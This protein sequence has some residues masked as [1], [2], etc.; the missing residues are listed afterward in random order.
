MTTRS[1]CL[2]T[3]MVLLCGCGGGAG[4]SSGNGGSSGN[5]PD[6]LSTADQTT[7]TAIMGD[8]NALRAQCGGVALADVSALNPLIISATKH[9]GYQALYDA[10]DNGNQPLLTHAEPDDI[11]ALYVN[12]AFF[13]RIE[14]AN[15][16]NDI[17]NWASYYEDIASQAGQPAITSLWNTVF[18]RLAMMRQGVT[19]AGYGDMAMAR[20]DYP[21]AHVATTDLWG[22]TPAGNGYAT[23][24]FTGY[25]TPSVTF[26]YWP[27]SG[28]TGVPSS[29]DTTTESPNP[30][31]GGP[32]VVGPP[33]HVICPTTENF[34]TLTVNLT[35]ASNHHLSVYVIVG[36]TALPTTITGDASASDA[37]VNP[38][39]LYPGE[40]FI[41][42]LA[43][44]AA[45]ST[46]SYWFT[47]SD[48]ESSPASFSA[49]TSATPLTFTTGP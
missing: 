48:T 6:V 26:S 28:T 5:L 11:L 14:D 27:A 2:L 22:N 8:L 33:L 18:H 30:L 42:P 20:A 34:G 29:F 10:A 13:I 1:A 7:N 45:S 39:D 38:A 12:N 46:Y 3:A 16:G 21:T 32:A 36:G 25:T 37:A 19:S 17:P 9:A 4:S 23:L 44:L 24:D 40:I 49:G 35:D 43:P 15:G 47:A 41:L 31:P